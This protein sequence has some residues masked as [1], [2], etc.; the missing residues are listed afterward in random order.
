M[1]SG[2]PNVT[3]S[4]VEY[5]R[6]VARLA[7]PFAVPDEALRS[8]GLDAEAFDR[9]ARQWTAVLA[10]DP[11]VRREFSRLY[12]AERGVPSATSA[13]ER[14]LSESGTSLACPPTD[15]G[16]PDETAFGAVP[17][18]GPVLPF[19]EGRFSPR[20]ELPLPRRSAALEPNPDETQ[21]L[22]LIVDLTP[23]GHKKPAR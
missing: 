7:E 12:R 5:V 16:N 9:A 6:A 21:A 22:G 18:L 19:V 17:A 3:L 1:I 2:A 8:L 14:G 23:F 10:R 4:L 15:T 20:P 13:G 11:N